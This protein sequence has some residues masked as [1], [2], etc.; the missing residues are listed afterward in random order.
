MG[1]P[2]EPDA[3]DSRLAFFADPF[4]NLF[5]LKQSLAS[6]ATH[7]PKNRDGGSRDVRSRMRYIVRTAV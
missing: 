5:E 6:N 2:F 1:E 3:I 7:E 4:G